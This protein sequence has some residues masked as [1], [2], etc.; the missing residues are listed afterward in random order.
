[1]LQNYSWTGSTCHLIPGKSVPFTQHLSYLEE[2][3]LMS[4]SPSWSTQA[5]CTCI[6]TRQWM[7]SGCS[8]LPQTTS[9][10]GTSRKCE[11]ETHISNWRGSYCICDITVLGL[12]IASLYDSSD[13]FTSNED[14]CC[15]FSSKTKGLYEEC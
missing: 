10:N 8:R 14:I 6:S 1:M 3:L 15:L 13:V 7:H 2:S 12:S 11:K 9:E 4:S 5:R